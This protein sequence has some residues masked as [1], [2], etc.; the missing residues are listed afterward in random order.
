[1]RH[2]PPLSLGAIF[3]GTPLSDYSFPSGHATFAWALA[4]VLSAKEP[5]LRIFYYIL[6]FLI[7]LSRIYLGAHYPADVFA[8]TV[9]G[10]AI[11]LFALWVEQKI[12]VNKIKKT[13]SLI[14]Y[15]L[16]I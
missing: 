11:G 9:I 8:G 5:R 1:M 6:A 3:V 13:L 4:V 10:V 2:R 16:C 14:K 12:I 15:N 7:S